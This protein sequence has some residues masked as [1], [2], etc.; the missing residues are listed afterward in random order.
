MFLQK[1]KKKLFSTKDK[2][3]KFII[4]KNYLSLVFL[5]VLSASQFVYLIFWYKLQTL[6]NI[7]EI[8]KNITEFFILISF[9]V[10]YIFTL[11][12]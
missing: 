9:F 8:M 11:I 7:L 6:I 5:F 2:I 4:N 12:P 1:T 3:H 10:V